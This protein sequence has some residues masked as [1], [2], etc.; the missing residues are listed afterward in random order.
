MNTDRYI[1]L[2]AKGAN[3]KVLGSIRGGV[4]GGAEA[5]RGVEVT[6]ETATL[7]IRS[8]PPKRRMRR[9]RPGAS[10]LWAR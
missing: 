9:A 5:L 7:G 3:A 8:T 10:R 6:A 1:V 4:L 2:K